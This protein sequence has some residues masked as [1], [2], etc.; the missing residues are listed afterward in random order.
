[1]TAPANIRIRRVWSD[2]AL[3]LVAAQGV[4]VQA[5][6][7]LLAIDMSTPPLQYVFEMKVF[8]DAVTKAPA[9]QPI[10]SRLPTRTRLHAPFQNPR[11]VRSRYIFEG[12]GTVSARDEVDVSMLAVLEAFAS[13]PPTG[14]DEG[15]IDAL[16][17]T[18]ASFKKRIHVM[19]CAYTTGML[20]EIET[21]AAH[22]LETCNELS[23]LGLETL[24]R[25]RFDERTRVTSRVARD[26]MGD[27]EREM[28]GQA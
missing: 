13:T 20:R 5:A 1:M 9:V 17:Y 8:N 15:V 3:L 26:I 25:L 7:E 27:I 11:L 16:A 12:G 10:R 24:E 18:G 23:T 6:G 4:S 14:G 21:G 22:D 19:W 2:G 28:A